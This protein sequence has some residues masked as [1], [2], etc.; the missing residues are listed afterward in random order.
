[1]IDLV[2][3]DTRKPA[4]GTYLDRLATSILAPH[5]HAGCPPDIVT[6]ITRNTQTCLRPDFLAFGF[7]DLWIDHSHLAVFVL[8]NEN[9]QRKGYL[10]SCQTCTMRF[11]HG[12]KHV[13]D[14]LLDG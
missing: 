4:L 2:L 7:D 5:N 10:R 12:L 13:I 11:M 6:G 3:E 9:T 1:M 8:S 14:Q